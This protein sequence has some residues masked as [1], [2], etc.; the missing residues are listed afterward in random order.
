MTNPIV[1]A[2]LSSVDYVAAIKSVCPAKWTSMD[3]END[4]SLIDTLGG[5]AGLVLS[6]GLFSGHETGLRVTVRIGKT[7]QLLMGSEYWGHPTSSIENELVIDAETLAT[8]LKAL[9]KAE[10]KR[11][12]V[13]QPYDPFD[14]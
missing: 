3:T 8:H 11:L 1:E 10:L 5:S 12:S 2:L 14:L 13:P 7:G 4:Y 9:I 6:Y